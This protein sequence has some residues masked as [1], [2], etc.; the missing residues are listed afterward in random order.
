MLRNR[1]QKVF[2]AVV[3]GD[4][5]A[6]ASTFGLWFLLQ[7]RGHTPELLVALPL[8]YITLAC[9][10][11]VH[12]SIRAVAPMK[13]LGRFFLFWLQ[14]VMGLALFHLLVDPWLPHGAG[15]ARAREIAGLLVGVLFLPNLVFF[16]AAV[17]KVSRWLRH[18]RDRRNVVIA[19]TGETARITAQAM[20]AHPDWGITLLGYLSTRDD[21]MQDPAGPG[22][23]VLGHYSEMPQLVQ[24]QV[25]DEVVV[26]DPGATI[27][28][29]EEVVRIAETI[30]LRAFVVADFCQTKSTTVDRTDLAG[31]TLL[32]LTPFPDRIVG[33]SFKRA[34]DIVGSAAGLLL[35]MPLF[36]VVAVA[37][38][39][40]S[41]GS[42]F[43]AQ[44][45]LG[46]NGR[47]FRFYKFR[48]MVVGADHMKNGLMKHNEMDGPVF[49]MKRDPRITKVGRFLRRY[50]IDE[51]PQLWNVL[52]GDMSL[53]GPRPPVPEEVA[54][55]E[56]WQRR[57]L[58]MKPGLTCVWQVNGRNNTDFQ[59]WMK[60]DLEYIDNWSFGRDVK[61]LL[62]TVPAVLTGRGAS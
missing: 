27:E 43:Y 42:I 37:I 6:I 11:R 18:D 54:V 47:P 55:Y 24:Q 25:V 7:P 1:P 13:L 59:T 5:L 30:G 41:K 44:T 2:W 29:V 21:P 61:I 9:V 26:A 17:L 40:N 46:R 8:T 50:S 35:L 4:G 45:R 49:K 12:A 14:M 48:T 36:A 52:M 33:G 34:V 28:C 57:R 31:R 23:K 3:L 39:L 16:R 22:M 32:V 60:Q 51:L 15:V 58:S 10:G 53:V 38:K 56:T 62:K 20:E 19:G